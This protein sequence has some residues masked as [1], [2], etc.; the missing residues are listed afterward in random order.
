MLDQVTPLV[1]TFNEEPNIRRTLNSLTWANSILVIDSFSSDETVGVAEEFPNASVTQRS[2]DTHTT[3][4]NFGLDQVPTPWVL[5]LDADYELSQGLIDEIKRLTPS[6]EISGY[7][8]RFEFR[9]FGH[10]LRAS[11]YPPRIVL[12]R[13]DKG[14]YVEDGHTQ[15]LRI[16]GQIEELKSVIIHDDRKPLS[17]WIQ[18]QDSYMKIEALHLLATPNSQLSLQDRL[19]KKIFLA[20]PIMFLYLLFVRGLILDGWPGWYYVKQR[21]LAEMLLSLRLLTE[22]EGLETKRNNLKSDG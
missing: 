2:F 3:Q 21:T 8:A 15:L 20:P 4:W 22:R 9:I 5:S 10:P 17:R 12:F 16:D 7:A 13:K 1:L 6:N 19:R 18:S 14:R 11:V